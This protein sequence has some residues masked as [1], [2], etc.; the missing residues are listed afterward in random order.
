MP[1]AAVAYLG[2]GVLQQTVNLKLNLIDVADTHWYGCSV[3]PALTIG[4]RGTL[5]S[6]PTQIGL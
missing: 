1:I 5:R 6:L 3:E 4:T 2:T